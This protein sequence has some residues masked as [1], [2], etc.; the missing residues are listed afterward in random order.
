MASIAQGFLVGTV[1]L[2]A[3]TAGGVWAAI[4]P[5]D[6]HSRSIVQHLAAGTV[7]AGLV[8]DVLR[9]LLTNKPEPIWLLAGLV[10]GLAAMLLIRAK[11]KT[12]GGSTLGIT[13]VADVIVDGLL[14]GLSITSGG[15]S[16]VLFV[17]GL[18]PEMALL[19][20]TVSQEFAG[21]EAGRR[22]KV[23]VPAV[24]GCFVVAGGALGAWA[25][26]GPSPVITVIEA[27]GAIALSYL[28][29]EE[30][31]R[32]AHE[33]AASP[34]LAATFFLGFIPLFAAGVLFG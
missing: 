19:G 12:D 16:A 10:L 26:S 5:P 11:G 28:V 20:V 32:E 29:M 3:L 23:A 30:L 14:L 18:V 8:V 2:A 21:R 25:R 24:V 27:F 15:A 34:A 33:Q 22:R 6:R 9:R 7:F 17:I 1:G 31:L 4:G 13:I